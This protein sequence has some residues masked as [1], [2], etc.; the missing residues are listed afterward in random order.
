MTRKI[1]K[2]SY[3]KN[4]GSVKVKQTSFKFSFRLHITFLFFF[5]WSPGLLKLL[6]QVLTK[7]VFKEIEEKSSITGTFME[8]CTSYHEPHEYVHNMHDNLEC[9][10][11]CAFI[12]ALMYLC[13]NALL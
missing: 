11:S 13:Q 3:I 7:Y 4:G 10:Q 2:I 1:K 12:L 8:L 9:I 5:V 6:Y